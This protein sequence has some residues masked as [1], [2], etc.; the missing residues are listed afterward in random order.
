MPLVPVTSYGAAWNP[1]TNQGRAFVQ[2]GTGPLTPIPIVNADEFIIILMM[3]S[4]TGVQFD[5]QTRE[6]QIPPRPVGT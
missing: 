6:I 3:M 5:T 1:A 2:I 4:K